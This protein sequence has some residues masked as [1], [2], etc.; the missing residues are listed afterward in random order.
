MMHRRILQSASAVAMMTAL[1]LLPEAQAS[2]PDRDGVYWAC[3]TKVLQVV[4]II[5]N[6]E[7]SCGRHET[8][9][10]WNKLGPRGPAG[11]QGPVGAMGPAGPQGPA[12]A[13]GPIGPQGP[14][15]ETGAPG[16]A[17]PQGPAGGLADGPCYSDA[18]RFQD[19]DNGTMTDTGSGLIWLQDANCFGSLSWLEAQH[20]VAALA[21]GQCS[22]ADGSVA[23]DWRMPTPEEWETLVSPARD[24]YCKGTK[25][26]D[27]EGSHCYDDA[28]DTGQP[29]DNVGGA[30][31][32]STTFT[33][34]PAEAWQ[35]DLTTSYY[36]I[37][38][39]TGT[40]GVWPVRGRR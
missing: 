35:M 9:I 21:D 17:G 8:L 12:G 30:Y 34:A 5:D 14:K 24:L 2:I 23:G 1:S 28:G 6:S 33:G 3:Y 27:T 31:W 38:N 26:T 29:F 20:A 15:G 19:C 13:P 22:L 11:P 37:R 40:Y 18:D 39:K 25:L 36:Q 16:P 32:A 7:D 4:R 10:K